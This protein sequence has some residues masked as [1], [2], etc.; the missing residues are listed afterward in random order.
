VISLI[1]KIKECL[2]NGGIFDYFDYPEM[3]DFEKD[4]RQCEAA[5]APVQGAPR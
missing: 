4:K 5:T 3:R 1:L 2:K